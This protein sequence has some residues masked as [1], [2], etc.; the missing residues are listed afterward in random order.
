MPQHITVQKFNTAWERQFVEEKE[1]IKSILKDNLVEIYHIGS[2]A[3][4]GLSAKP[5]IDMMPAVF[6]LSKVDLIANKFEQAGYEYMGEFGIKGR[7]YL[8]KG[9]DERTHQI[10]IFQKDDASN[11]KRHLAVRD[12]L[13]E[14]FDEAQR[15]GKLKESLA[16]QFQYDI[17]GYCDGKEE[18]MQSLEQLAMEWYDNSIRLGNICEIDEIM[19]IWKSENIR[20]HNFISADYWES[21]YCA[22]KSALPQ[23]GIYVYVCKGEIMGFIGLNGN[24][25]EGIFV[26]ADCQCKG[27]GKALLNKVKET[28]SDLNLSVYKKNLNAVTFYLKNAFAVVSEGIDDNTNEIEYTMRWTK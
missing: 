20:A 23:A 15:Y 1:L 5:I 2:T 10:H 8:R 3:V 4:K 19:Q 24:Y 7:R 21:N 11:I 13:R 25:I 26:K 28:R 17:E 18:F 12:Y 16:L 27:I 9:G 22:V 14:H 6:D